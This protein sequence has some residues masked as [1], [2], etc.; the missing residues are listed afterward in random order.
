MEANRR[1]REAAIASCANSNRERGDEVAD[2]L[3]EL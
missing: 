2:L 3:E 1:S